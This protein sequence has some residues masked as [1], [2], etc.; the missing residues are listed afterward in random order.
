MVEELFQLVL[1][2]C[3]G[4]T[5]T[6]I[7]LKIKISTRK[8]KGIPTAIARIARDKNISP[9]ELQHYLAGTLA[10][11]A[12]AD[13]HFGNNKNNTREFRNTTPNF[14][15]QVTCTINKPFKEK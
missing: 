1:I 14:G 15:Y 13:R 10:L 3:A 5:V 9:Q 4:Y 6:D 7:Y 2:A 8:D 11:L 12:E